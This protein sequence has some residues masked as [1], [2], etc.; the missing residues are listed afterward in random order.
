[1]YTSDCRSLASEAVEAAPVAA[2]TSRIA[3]GEHVVPRLRSGLGTAEFQR[4]VAEWTGRRSLWCFWEKSGATRVRVPAAAIAFALCICVL[5]ADSRPALLES[6]ATCTASGTAIYPAAAATCAADGPGLWAAAAQHRRRH[7]KPTGC[8]WLLMVF[9]LSGDVESNPGPELRIFSQNVCS[10]KNKLGTLRTHAAELAG[11]D[12]ICLTETWLSSHVADSE[13]MLGLPDF[14]WFRK[15]RSSRGG[16]VAC[17]VKLCLSPVH[18][19]DLETDC[20]SLVIQLGTTRSAFLAVCYRAPDADRET[21]RIA[22]LLRGL[23][24]TGR[25]LLLVGDF[26]LPESTGRETEWPV[27]GGGPRGRSPSSTPSRSA[28]R[29]SR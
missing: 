14:T 21:E 28:A 24:R 10:I 17:A 16:G 25:P 8:R 19:P 27:C 12:A 3:D 18:R 4:A 26:N 7:L 22:D 23:H 29:C 11:Y 6:A 15:D 5:A 1:M 9:L 2:M 20:E 13:L